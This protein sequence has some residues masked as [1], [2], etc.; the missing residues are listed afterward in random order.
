MAEARQ[1]YAYNGWANRRSLDA[2]EGL[3]EGRADA[4]APS[5]YPSLRATLAH[6]LVAEWFWLR[7]WL[8]E[9]PTA[10]P[11]GMEEAGLP[12]IR[13]WLLE[14]EEERAR[15]LEGLSDADLDRRMSFR[16]SRGDEYTH[17]LAD[18]LRHVANHSTYHRGQLATQMRQL[19]E[20]PPGTDMILYVLETA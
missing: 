18:M 20:A 4:E 13:E 6:L 12:R 3:P 2:V 7:R 9:S 8:G 5:S 16:D 17:R 11:E 19:G 10:P 1:L 14:V 15:F